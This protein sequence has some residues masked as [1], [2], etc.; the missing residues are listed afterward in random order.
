[1]GAADGL[2]KFR[3]DINCSAPYK[4]PH[5]HVEIF[6]NVKNNHISVK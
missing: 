4:N 5:S 3:F 6:K 1:M 2:K